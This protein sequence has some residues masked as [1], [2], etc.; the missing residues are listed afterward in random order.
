MNIKAINLSNNPLPSY[1]TEGSA[2]IDFRADVEHAAKNLHLFKNTEL[3]TEGEDAPKAVVHPGGYCLLPSGLKMQI[4]DGYVLLIFSRSGHGVKNAVT[5]SNS[6]GVIDSD[7]RGEIGLTLINHGTEDFVLYH[8][9]RVAQGIILPYP[10]IEFEEV[11][12]LDSTVRGE[13][14]YQSSG[15][16]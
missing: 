3:I 2:C 14:G 11:T 7:Y 12:E 15:V 13:G 1:A 5:L 6:V 10:K 16:K 8:G 9:D 4:P